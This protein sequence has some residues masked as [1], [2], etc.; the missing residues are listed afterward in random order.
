MREAVGNSLLFNLVI[1]F[2]TVVILMFVGILAYSKAYRVK[3]RMIELLEK[4][5]TY[6]DA[7][8]EIN[9]NLS[10]FGYRITNR[11]YC[12]SARI[13]NRLSGYAAGKVQR[14]DDNASLANNYNYCLFEVQG[15]LSVDGSTHS[16]YYIVVTFVQ[17]DFPVIGD[18]L[19]IPVF[20]ETKIL[21]KNY[22]Y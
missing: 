3:N 16:K 12:D 10:N 20:G 19:V 22:N 11:D 13:Q 5:E 8:D 9:E 1:V 14:I 7:Y 2:V 17:F 21:G 18:L 6:E 4:H 15:D